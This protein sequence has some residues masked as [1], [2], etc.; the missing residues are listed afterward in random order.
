M[1]MLGHRVREDLFD[2]M[3]LLPKTLTS[4]PFR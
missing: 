4:R 2:I 1:N 3:H